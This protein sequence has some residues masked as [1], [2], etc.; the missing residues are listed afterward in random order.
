MTFLF[1][2]KML[3]TSVASLYTIYI[4]VIASTCVLNYFYMLCYMRVKLNTAL[5]SF[6]TISTAFLH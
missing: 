6:S 1:L 4:A 5:S 3:H 2:G